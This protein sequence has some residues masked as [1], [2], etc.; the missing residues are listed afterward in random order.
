MDLPN[1]WELLSWCCM[2]LSLVGNIFVVR[3]QVLGQWI[4]AV[5]NCGW[6]AYNLHIHA[7]AATCLFTVYFGLCV[8]GI[9]AWS[10]EAEAAPSSS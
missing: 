2:C 7:P 5:S 6:I 4:W 1:G 3:K 10:K 9:I 8:W